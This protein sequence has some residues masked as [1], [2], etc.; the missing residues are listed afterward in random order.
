VP[1]RGSTKLRVSFYKG[2]ATLVRAYAELAGN[3]TEAGYSNAEAAALQTEVE[4]YTDTRATHA[5]RW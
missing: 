5:K 1:P 4:F 2:V 3:L